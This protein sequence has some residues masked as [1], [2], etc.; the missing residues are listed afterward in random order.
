MHRLP[1]KVIT[2]DLQVSQYDVA[3]DL[4]VVS[5]LGDVSTP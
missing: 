1:T 4:P 5:F 2:R 3:A